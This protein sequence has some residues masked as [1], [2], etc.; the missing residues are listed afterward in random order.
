MRPDIPTQW[1][2]SQT[3]FCP[4]SLNRQDADKTRRRLLLADWSKYS[5]PT[6]L[7]GSRYRIIMI[8]WINGRSELWAE[9]ESSNERSKGSISGIE[10][11]ETT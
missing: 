1:I 3:H 11:S 4:I 6:R 2:S 7:P 5:I 8:Q 10:D 9:L